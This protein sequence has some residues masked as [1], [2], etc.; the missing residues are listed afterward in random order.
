[1]KNRPTRIG[2][3]CAL[4]AAVLVVG[5][6]ASIGLP[7]TARAATPSSPSASP[8]DDASTTRT[9][10]PS[11]AATSS[12]APTPTTSVD[13]DTSTSA[14]GW[15]L[16]VRPSALT[17]REG[18]IASFTATFTRS[19][20][21]A[22]PI[23]VR[24]QTARARKGPWADLGGSSSTVLASTA[25]L[26]M[27]G[28]LFRAVVSTD[29]ESSRS[30]SVILHVQPPLDTPS[31]TPSAA[32]TATT[33]MTKEP[34]G[35][36]ALPVLGKGQEQTATGHNFPPGTMVRVTV[37]PTGVDLGTYLVDPEGV[38]TTRFTTRSLKPGSHTVRWTPLSLSLFPSHPP[39]QATAAPNH[40][41]RWLSRS[42]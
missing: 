22:S 19:G 8:R 35:T 26:M 6:V 23:T 24:W 33:L 42:A 18:Q 15:V 25:T 31:A 28:D 39:A 11:P 13:T 12:E 20:P 10:R 21:G 7:A 41:G 40:L 9:T 14:T 32:P 5:L 4:R 34:Y 1:M 16:A 27:D 29:Q 3:A 2:T 38:V 37:E 17:V 30:T 36:V